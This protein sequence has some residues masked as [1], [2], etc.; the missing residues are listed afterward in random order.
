L[1]NKTR[2]RK[3]TAPYAESLQLARTFNQHRRITAMEPKI[4]Q[5]ECA[6]CGRCWKSAIPTD[7]LTELDIINNIVYFEECSYCYLTVDERSR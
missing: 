7:E 4:S 2:Y 6:N 5:C 1:R 3:P